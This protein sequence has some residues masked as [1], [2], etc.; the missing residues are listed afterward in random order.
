MSRSGRSLSDA[1][2]L[3]G[4]GLFALGDCWGAQDEFD[5]ALVIAETTPER[6]MDVWSLKGDCFVELQQT[7]AASDAY[8]Q[9]LQIARQ[10]G[11]AEDI[12]YFEAG[13]APVE[14]A[15]YPVTPKEEGVCTSENGSKCQVVFS[16][17]SFCCSP[18]SP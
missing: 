18:C 14:R 16:S 3:R 13:A 12:A 1:R 15:R 11:S 7:S 4:Q 6:R 2:L 5:A 17:S 8:N 10:L 9:A